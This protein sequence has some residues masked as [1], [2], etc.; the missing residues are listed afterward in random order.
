M[1]SVQRVKE[2][3]WIGYSV[4][5]QLFLST[6]E[7]SR[8]I[9]NDEFGRM[10]QEMIVACCRISHAV[11]RGLASGPE[12]LSKHFIFIS[13]ARKIITLI[14]STVFHVSSLFSE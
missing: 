13:T 7:I 10:W 6:A 2:L 11:V 14:L 3:S 4:N 9:M 1:R 5:L 8:L 12:S